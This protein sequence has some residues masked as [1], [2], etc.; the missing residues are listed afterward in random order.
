M[1]GHRAA[2]GIVQRIATYASKLA[3][4]TLLLEV[5]ATMLKVLLA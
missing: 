4:F 3:H 2:S 5:V 1:I